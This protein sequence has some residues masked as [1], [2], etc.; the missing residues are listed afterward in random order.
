MRTVT[1]DT[2]VADRRDGD[3]I[4]AAQR[5]GLEVTVVPMTDREMRLSNYRPGVDA[6]ISDAF[7]LAYCQLGTMALA[8]SEILEQILH[9]IGNGSFP[10]PD[11]RHDLTN[12]Q[13]RQFRD[14]LILAAHGRKRR[15]IFVSDDRKAFVRHGRRERLE[16]LLRTRIMTSSEF[17]Q[18][19]GEDS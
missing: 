4:D 15:D 7:V 2:N 19:A 16:H 6:R 12:G 14:A 8:S 5:R 1:L 10:K 18:W 17:L 3:V 11:C 13:R 9:I